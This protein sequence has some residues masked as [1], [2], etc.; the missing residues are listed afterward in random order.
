MERLIKFINITALTLFT[1]VVSATPLVIYGEDNRVD[2]IESNR[3]DYVELS[4]STAAMISNSK[5]TYSYGENQIQV[6]TRKL[7][8][9][10]ICKDERFANQ[11][12]VS[13]CS[14]FLVGDKYLVTA[15]HCVKDEYDCAGN[16]WF[17]NYKMIDH[18]TAKTTFSPD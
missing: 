1:T 13:S 16:K 5:V 12:I 3:S 7:S 15:G 9:I 17:F 6:K 10:G 2:V 8:E 4:K 14:G 18:Q 11:P